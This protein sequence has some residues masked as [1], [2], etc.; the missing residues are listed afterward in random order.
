MKTGLSPTVPTYA[1]RLFKHVLCLLILFTYIYFIESKNKKAIIQ[2][3]E[4]NN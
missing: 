1:K 4:I 2:L 3:S